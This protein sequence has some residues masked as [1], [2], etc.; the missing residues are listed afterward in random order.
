MVVTVIG[1]SAAPPSGNTSTG[2]PA[3]VRVALTSVYCGFALC[4]HLVRTGHPRLLGR[5]R[6]EA[7]LKC[8][9]CKQVQRLLA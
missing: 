6:G 2:L 3:P 1:S 9:A 5:L 8:P 7:E 4:G